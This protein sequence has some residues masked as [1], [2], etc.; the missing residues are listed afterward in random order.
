[1]CTSER[2]ECGRGELRLT[3]RVARRRRT[4]AGELAKAFESGHSAAHRIGR[5]GMAD[6]VALGLGAPE[7]AQHLQLVNAL[8][9]FGDHV[10]TERATHR[11]DGAHE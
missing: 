1:M 2:T 7:I 11:N 3:S 4:Q 8:H 10:E 5:D 6:E 9:A